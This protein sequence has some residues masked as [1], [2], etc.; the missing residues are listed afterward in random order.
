M[1]KDIETSIGWG[2]DTQYNDIEY[3]DIRHNGALRNDIQHNNK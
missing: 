2:H 1:R 3:Y